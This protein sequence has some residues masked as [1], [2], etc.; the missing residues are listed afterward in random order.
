MAFSARRSGRF[1]AVLAEV[2]IA[3]ESEMADAVE[4][5]VARRVRRFAEEMNQAARRLRQAG[6]LEKLAGALVDAAAPF[7]AACAVFETVGPDLVLRAARGVEG[8]A[9]LPFESAGAFRTA[10][11]TGDPV[12]A[13]ATSAEISQAIVDLFRHTANE[14]V[15]IFPFGSRLF[16]YAAGPVQ[17]EP[18]ELLA[19]VA[20]AVLPAPRQP[21][22]RADLVAIVPAEVPP[23]FRAAPGMEPPSK[24]I[25]D[26]RQERLHL[27]AQQYARAEVARIRLNCVRAVSEGR[28]R[29]DLYGALAGEVDALRAGFQQK[30]A[31]TGGLMVDYVHRE[32]LRTLANENPALLGPGY[33]GPLV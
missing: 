1:S 12:T 20:G 27:R 32:I 4:S 9:V 31:S 10:A 25:P 18:L 11:E 16:L 29:S 13:L 14:R 23:P 26:P 2:E 6:D 21:A 8:G 15:S 5:E 19:Q 30:F 3:L 22:R 17:G 28:L 24:N 7:C 33:P